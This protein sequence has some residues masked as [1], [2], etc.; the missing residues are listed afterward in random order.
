MLDAGNGLMS[1]PGL[2]SRDI[3]QGGVTSTGLSQEMMDLRVDQT[4]T[5]CGRDI[6]SGT[7]A[8]DGE[9]S[10]IEYDSDIE[11]FPIRIPETNEPRTRMPKR[12]MGLRYLL[13]TTGHI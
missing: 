10:S 11:K 8:K 6:A 3:I 7:G 12:R 9:F 13:R 1:P 2:S 4:Q 5:L